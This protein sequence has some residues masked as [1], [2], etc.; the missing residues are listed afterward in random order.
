MCIVVNI[1]MWII[2]YGRKMKTI[3]MTLDEELLREVD[4]VTKKLKTTRSE[5]IR[6]ALHKFLDEL[7]TKDLEK[8]HCEGYKKYPVKQNEFDIWEN[9]QSWI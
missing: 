3:Q 5:F 9:E 4:K 1:N 2:V 8:L 6:R 7:S